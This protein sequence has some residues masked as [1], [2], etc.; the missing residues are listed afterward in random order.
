MHSRILRRRKRVE[1]R[2]SGPMFDVLVARGMEPYERQ[3]HL[4]RVLPNGPDELRDLSESGR[5]SILRRLAQA[6]REERNSGRA[7]PWTYDRNRQVAWAAADATE[8]GLL[9]QRGR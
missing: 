4:P 9:A 8:R 6:L 3:R 5:R 1:P 2:A 7:G